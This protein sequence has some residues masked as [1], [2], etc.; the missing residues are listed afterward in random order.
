MEYQIM[1]TFDF[2]DFRN[3]NDASLNEFTLFWVT[4]KVVENLGLFNRIARPIITAIPTMEERRAF[5][6]Y[7]GAY[8]SWR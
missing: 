3:F 4:S 2:R 1:L 8:F 6:K 7:L 5:A